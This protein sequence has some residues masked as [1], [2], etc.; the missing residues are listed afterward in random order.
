[1]TN[2]TLGHRP[3]THTATFH[4][5]GDEVAG[6]G[7]A[8]L[9]NDILSKPWRSAT[10]DPE[11]TRFRVTL[12]QLRLVNSLW[13]VWHNLTRDGQVRLR[14]YRNDSG[15][16]QLVYDSGFQSWLSEVYDEELVDWDGGNWHDRTYTDEELDSTPLY[17]P[18]YIA[19]SLYTD[20]IIIDIYDPLNPAGYVEVG[21]MPIEEAI[22]IPVNPTYGAT[23]GFNV[24][25][26]MEE[27][28]G[29]YED[30]DPL[31]KPRYFDGEI[32]YMETIAAK[33]IFY[34]MQRQLDIHRCMTFWLDRDDTQ[35]RL[36][37]AWLARQDKS[38]APIQ[39]KTF[40]SAG[41]RIK[42]KEVIG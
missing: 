4:A 38:M 9:Q 6:Y 25:T 28:E 42:L 13:L 26:T 12:P 15:E 31:D 18:F 14:L 20:E 39:Y 41:I 29:G 11:D 35:N 40:D 33:G 30:F 10:L 22:E 23:S 34:E 32:E 37:D 16:Q 21:F 5:L 8:Q 19:G 17:D 3:W 1:M 36:R 7:V 24:R 2:I 27:A